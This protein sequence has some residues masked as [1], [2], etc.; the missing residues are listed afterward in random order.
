MVTLALILLAAVF[1]GL[2]TFGAQ[3]PA[4]FRFSP[5]GQLCLALAYLFSVWPK[6]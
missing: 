6:G 1:F 4:H 5:A 2:A 3:E